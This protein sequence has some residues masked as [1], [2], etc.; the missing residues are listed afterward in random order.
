MGA[1]ACAT[2]LRKSGE[3]EDPEVDGAVHVD[4]KNFLIRNNKVFSDVHVND[5]HQHRHTRMRWKRKQS[6]HCCPASPKSEHEKMV[7]PGGSG[8]ESAPGGLH[9][10]LRFIRGDIALRVDYSPI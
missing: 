4:L 7:V 1:R 5:L 6:H 3:V 10:Q 2:R 8:G 9:Q